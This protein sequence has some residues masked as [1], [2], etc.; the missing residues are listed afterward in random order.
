[1]DFIFSLCRSSLARA[2]RAS[3]KQHRA[4][5]CQSA[6]AAGD[7]ASAGGDWEFVAA[8]PLSPVLRSVCFLNLARPG[9]FS[10]GSPVL[11]GGRTSSKDSLHTG[12]AKFSCESAM[13]SHWHHLCLCSYVLYD[14]LYERMTQFV[15]C[16]WQVTEFET[17]VTGVNVQDM[18]PTFDRSVLFV[19]MGLSPT[20]SILSVTV[21][22]CV[23]W[24]KCV[25][26]VYWTGI[27]CVHWT[28]PQLLVISRCQMC[29]T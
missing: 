9:A 29:L 16:Q 14:L 17:P 8:S 1:M 12:V 27:T 6:V 7:V 22:K 21:Y 25:G 18:P 10:H 23:G 26:Y 2:N 15:C 20:A 3:C 5:C 19:C 24:K 13:M 4:F 11:W 28:C